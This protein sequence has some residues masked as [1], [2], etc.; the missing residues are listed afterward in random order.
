MKKNKSWIRTLSLD[1][2]GTENRFLFYAWCSAVFL[3]L[4]L[5][6][7]LNTASVSFLGVAESREFQVNFENSAE[8]KHLYVQPGQIVKKGD[9]LAE[10]NQMD[11]DLQLRVLKSRYDKLRAER[12]LRKQISR[13]TQDA[14]DLVAGADPLLVDIVDTRR[15]MELIENRRRN[16][17]VFAE[18]EGTVGGVNFKIGEKVPAFAAVITLLPM[19]PSYVNGYLNE[20]LIS[21]VK[22][23]EAVEVVSSTGKT[24]LGQVASV[25]ARIVPIPERLLRIQTLTAW[26]REVIIKIP[27]QNGFLL[28]EKVSVQKGWGLSLLRKAQ[29]DELR[30]SLKKPQIYSEPRDIIFPESVREKLEPEISGIAYLPEMKQFALISDDNPEDR[31]LILLMNEDGE[32][33]DRVLPIERLEKMEDIESLSSEGD[34]LYLLS[35]QSKTKRGKEKS[36]RSLFARVLRKG[37]NLRLEDEVELRPL[38]LQAMAKSKDKVLNEIAA[39]ADEEKNELEIEGHVVAK[40]KLYL[41]LKGPVLERNQG[42]ILVVDD[43]DKLFESQELSPQ[44]IKVNS[45]FHMIPARDDQEMRLTDIFM[46]GETTYFSTSCRQQSCSAIWRLSRETG[47]AVRLAD[48]ELPRLEGLSALPQRKELIGVFDI[49]NG[50]KFVVVPLARSSGGN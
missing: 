1:V 11:L 33:L 3:I 14:G 19:N 30:M 24:I 17:F 16:L 4:A 5:G 39:R 21:S 26:G 28:G 47:E 48:F 18:V 31:P 8:I 45:R 42:I 27:P 15:E 34:L 25:G 2:I 32:V 38:L 13:I 36:Q 40:G 9:L 23:G 12:E 6:I 49:K 46:V 22:V 37:L 50:G 41:A 29:A 20:H 44:E 10:L 7:I 43:V 35:S